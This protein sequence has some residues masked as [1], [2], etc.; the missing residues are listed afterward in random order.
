VAKIY[1][2]NSI[3]VILTGMGS[4]GSNGIKKLK[5]AGGKVIAEDESTCVVYSMPKSVIEN[6]TKT[7]GLYFA[8]Q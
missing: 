3:G 2:Q 1:R 5:L 8:Y 6:R 4:D 7:G